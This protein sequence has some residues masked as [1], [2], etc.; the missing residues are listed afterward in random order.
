MEQGNKLT[1]TEFHDAQ[2]VQELTIRYLNK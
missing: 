2:E 1:Q